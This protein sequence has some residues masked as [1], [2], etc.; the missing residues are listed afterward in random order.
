MAFPYVSRIDTC[1]F[2]QYEVLYIAKYMTIFDLLF[3]LAF[4]SA[5][6]A[7]MV[8]VYQAIRGRARQAGGILLRL[9]IA[10]AV[11]LGIVVLVSVSSPRR[12]LQRGEE[13]CFDEWC[14]AVSK[15][16]RV[17]SA[18]DVSY[19]VALRLF[20]QA[21][22]VPQRANDVE[23][24]LVDSRDNRY[25]PAPAPSEPPFNVLLQPGES[26]TTTRV[27]RAPIDAR[28]VGLVLEHGGS[29]PG[30]FIIGDDLSLLHKRTIV[31]LD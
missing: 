22:R 26:V 14:Y 24:Y 19:T 3:I 28:D 1:Q 18:A 9:V 12:V 23:V 2:A 17:P 21:K 7:L 27:F 20:S 5:V 8:A 4:L 13:R 25:E 30:R 29:G 15:V 10:A 11:Y 6:A 16:S 31:R